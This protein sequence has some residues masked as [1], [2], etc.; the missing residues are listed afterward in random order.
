M[1]ER[2]AEPDP[3]EATGVTT[4]ADAGD[5]RSRPG[6]PAAA[7]PAATRRERELW[8]RLIQARYGAIFLAGVASMVIDVG[9]HRAWVAA[10]LLG[11]GLPYNAGYDWWMRRTGELHPALAY[12]DHALAVGFVAL[13]P[14]LLLSLIHI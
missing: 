2:S 10:S 6:S 9:P 4:P 11:I 7:A 13:A 8:R 1:G 5:E 3:A 14:E 12:T